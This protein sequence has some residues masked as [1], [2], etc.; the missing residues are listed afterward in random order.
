MPK[1]KVILRHKLVNA[2]LMSRLGIIKSEGDKAYFG[3]KTSG[4]VK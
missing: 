4:Q 1:L 3:G 2:I